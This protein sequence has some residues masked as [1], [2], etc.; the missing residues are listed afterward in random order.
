MRHGGAPTAASRFNSY[1]ELMNGFQELSAAAVNRGG[2]GLDTVRF[3]HA[4]SPAHRSLLGQVQAVLV[5][6]QERG[7]ASRIKAAAAWPALAARLQTA[8][9][10]AERLHLSGSV[11][12]AVVDDI[13]I[14]GR[15]Y[16][17][18][19]Q[20]KAEPEVETPDDYA[21][22][23]QAMQGL[24]N[25][26]ARM[27]EPSAGMIREEVAG[28]KD[29]TVS[30]AVRD[31]NTR[32]RD[33]LAA[34]HFGSHLNRRHAAVLGT[35]RTALLDARSESP[36]SAARAVARWQA[37]QGELRH[38]LGRAPD[39]VNG[40]IGLIQQTFEATGEA[41]SGHY[42]AVHGENLRTALTKERPPEQAR[43]ER[44]MAEAMGP[45]AAKALAEARVLE[46]FGFAL[47]VL[48]H[49]L[50]P[51]PDH[52]GEW[53]LTSGSTV[54]RVRGDQVESLRAS[55]GTAL[56]SFM[57]SLTNLVSSRSSLMASTASRSLAA[58]SGCSAMTP[59]IV[60]VD[61]R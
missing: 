23:I 24:L 12:A 61:S 57:A 37:I 17:H 11:L 1:A 30:Q 8:V 35:L 49:Q 2:A 43:T 18:A 54:I 25:T 7:E 47:N 21:D 58:R 46:D 48:E 27:G 31:A 52:A 42:A 19:R 38:V 13:A 15:T 29:A 40:D 5:Q 59:S 53:I 44:A 20:G 56:K 9:A 4:L 39:F 50:T 55:A 51:S 3:A 22:T 16:V 33:A 10:E 41:L 28:R 26:F 60:P 36:G 34:V 32:Q 6:A 14:L 45:T